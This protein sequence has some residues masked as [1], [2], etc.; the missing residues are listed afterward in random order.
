[1]ANQFERGTKVDKAEQTQLI[2]LSI[3]GINFLRTLHHSNPEFPSWKNRVTELLKQ[4]YGEDSIEYRRFVN[5]PGKAFVVRTETGMTEEYLRKLDC[6][7][8][9]LKSLVYEA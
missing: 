8:T 7:E 5:A 2:R 4:V 9:A 3:D 1:M 6:Y